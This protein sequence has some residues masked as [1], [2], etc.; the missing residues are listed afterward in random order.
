MFGLHGA[1]FGSQSKTNMQ[2]KPV[3]ELPTHRHTR[4]LPGPPA[5]AWSWTE[6]ARCCVWERGKGNGRG[7]G[8]E[9]RRCLQ[10]D[11]RQMSGGRRGWHGDSEDSTTPSGWSFAC[12]SWHSVACGLKERVIKFYLYYQESCLTVQLCEWM[13]A[14]HPGPLRWGSWRKWWAWRW[15]E[16]VK[17]R[18]GWEWDSEPCASEH[19][20]WSASPQRHYT[21][22]CEAKQT[23]HTDTVVKTSHKPGILYLKVVWIILLATRLQKNSATSRNKPY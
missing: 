19:R 20:R 10:K 15:G 5:A 16:S 3:C 4:S 7:R 23:T 17:S 9:R 11:V 2:L 22:A 12:P 13:N 8:T 14:S 6:P 18:G 1:V 21:Q